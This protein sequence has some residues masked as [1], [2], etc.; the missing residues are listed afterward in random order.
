LSVNKY[1]RTRT[2]VIYTCIRW[3]QRKLWWKFSNNANVQIAC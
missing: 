1:T 3:S 2:I